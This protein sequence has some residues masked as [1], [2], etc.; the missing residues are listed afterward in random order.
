MPFQKG[1]KLTKSGKQ[2]NAGRPTKADITAK[3]AKLEIQERELAIAKDIWEKEI[4]KKHKALAKRYVDRAMKN[5]VMLR[6][7]RRTV[8]P[9]AQNDK[10]GKDQ[11]PVI[12]NIIDANTARNRAWI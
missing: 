11:T 10:E 1:H 4:A 2:P 7:L 9:D 8:L 3:K 12:Y 6:D 5:D